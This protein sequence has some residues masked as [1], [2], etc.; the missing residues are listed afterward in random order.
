MPLTGSF[1]GTADAFQ[2]MFVKV[3]SH[4]RTD[5]YGVRSAGRLRDLRTKFC[6]RRSVLPRAVPPRNEFKVKP[7]DDRG[8]TRKGDLGNFRL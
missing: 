6:G 2:A 3:R 4:H 5:R 7:R 1:V 8:A